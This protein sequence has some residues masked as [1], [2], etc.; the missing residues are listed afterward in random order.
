MINLHDLLF[1]FGNCLLIT[2]VHTTE[3]IDEAI[4]LNMDQE[5][6]TLIEILKN[7]YLLPPPPKKFAMPKNMLDLNGQ[8]GQPKFVNNKIFKNKVKKG[9]YVEAGAYDGQK[10]SNSLFYE[11]EKGWD[12]LLVEAHPEAFARMKKRK[13]KAWK[14]GNCLSTKT[15]P[16]IV[17]FDAAGLLGGI[18][19]ED[20]KPGGDMS[21]D[22]EEVAKKLLGASAISNV[23]FLGDEYERKTVKSLC[24]P[25]Y[26]ILL[27]LENPT[28]HYLSLDVEGSEFPILKTIPFDKVDIKVLDVEINHAGSIFPGSAK[29]I[30]TYLKSQGYNLYAIL[31]RQ[32]AIYVKR[33]FLDEINE[34]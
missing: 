4:L 27:A 21:Q 22:P 33:G 13:R 23:G 8:I 28:V 17:D 16:E 2:M 3:K 12:G 7:E 29:D 31:S 1:L 24:F 32:D 15:T 34:L 18:I 19:H 30:D 6:P 25:L 5:D 14:L 10:F 26:S 9:F 11:V 20:L